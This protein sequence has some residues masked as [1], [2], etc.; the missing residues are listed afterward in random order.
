MPS[1]PP[2]RSASAQRERLF[3]AGLLA[4][5]TGLFVAF[6]MVCSQ[7]VRKARMRDVSMQVQSVAIGDCLQYV[8]RA[9]LN[10][11]ASRVDPYNSRAATASGDK[12]ASAADAARAL[13]GNSAAPGAAYR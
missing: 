11:C 13:M 4:L 12:P 6:W 8:P 10:S 7:Q 3:R 9:T 2:Q 5:A 1:D